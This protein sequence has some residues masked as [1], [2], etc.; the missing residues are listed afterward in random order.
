MPSRS[1]FQ[2]VMQN[3]NFTELANVFSK[4]AFKIVP[5]EKSDW[6]SL[7][8]KAIGGTTTNCHNAA[9]NF[10]SLVTVFVSKRK[11]AI[12]A[13]SINSKKESEILKVRKLIKM[14]DL[15]G[16]I[17]TLDALHCQKKTVKAIKES[18][19]DYV[20]GVKG[21]QRSLQRQLKKTLLVNR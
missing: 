20:I 16:L 17:L 12:A 6:V 13:G 9:Q 14:L 8:G 10:I 15:E 1:V 3:I 19:N 11:Q 7:D 21:N 5:L 2:S 18:G 4:W